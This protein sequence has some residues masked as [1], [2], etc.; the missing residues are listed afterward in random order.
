MDIFIAVAQLIF[1]LM[2]YDESHR[3]QTEPSTTA[4]GTTASHDAS[5][6][7]SEDGYGG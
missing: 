4:E 3:G 7:D 6:F 2:S 1:L 5:L